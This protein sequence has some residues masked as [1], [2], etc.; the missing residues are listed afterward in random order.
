MARKRSQQCP[1]CGNEID[2]IN[3]WSNKDKLAVKCNKCENFY[4]ISFYKNIKRKAI[5]SI[6]ISLIILLIFIIIDSVG[7]WS[8]LFVALP[9]MVFYAT[10]TSDM[11]LQ[12]IPQPSLQISD[13]EHSLNN[14][15]GHFGYQ[16]SFSTNEQHTSIMPNIRDV[17]Y[18][19]ADYMKLDENDIEMTRKIDINLYDDR[20]L[21][22]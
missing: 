8:V 21:D 18:N 20:Y 17:K 15:N 4:G 11:V 19:D 2:F 12:A 3:L 9:F 22:S 7:L 6:F 10:F 14:D 16:A 1:Y 5:L 13:Q